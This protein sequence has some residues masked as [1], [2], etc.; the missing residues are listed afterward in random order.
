MLEV[1]LCVKYFDRKVRVYKSML[2]DVRVFQS[3]TLRTKCRSVF[4]RSIRGMDPP[5]F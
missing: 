3:V 5:F 2:N 4:S 1:V